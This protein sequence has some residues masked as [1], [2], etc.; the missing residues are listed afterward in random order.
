M[1]KRRLTDLCKRLRTDYGV[2]ITDAAVVAELKALGHDVKSASSSLEE[3]VWLD[4]LRDLAARH[5]PRKTTPER[6]LVKMARPQNAAPPRPNVPAPQAAAPY[7]Q[8]SGEQELFITG[9]SIDATDAHLKAAFA[10]HGKVLSAIVKRDRTTNVSRGFGFVRFAQPVALSTLQNVTVQ[11]V[12][13]RVAHARPQRTRPTLPSAP[14]GAAS[15]ETAALAPPELAWSELRD[16]KGAPHGVLVQASPEHSAHLIARFAELELAGGTPWHGG[17]VGSLVADQLAGA[18]SVIS[19][20]L[21]AGQLMQVIGKP[22]LLAG[23][24]NG[25][26]VM[27]ESADGLL[28]SVVSPGR[29]GIVGNLRFAKTSLAPV[30]APVLAWQVLH[31]I[32]GTVQL[33]QINARLD[34][35]QRGLETLQERAEAEILGQVI[36]AIGILDDILE[37]RAT[38]GTFTAEMSGRLAPVE[39][40]IGSL[41]NRNRTLVERF[42]LKARTAQRHGGKAGAV[43]SA[44]LAREQG[45]QAMHDMELLIALMA[46]DLRVRRA[47]LLVAIERNPK[48]TERRVK[49]VAAKIEEYQELLTNFPSVKQLERHARA[50]VEEMGWWS[51]NVFSRGVVEH[52]DSLGELNLADVRPRKL[53]PAQ[54]TPSYVLWRDKHGVNQVRILGSGTG[55]D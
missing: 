1:S 43:R 44:T 47:L 15:Y 46:G 45:P 49:A 9:V 48:D 35:M 31:A 14:E 52:V 54:P 39:Q 20:G 19:S 37:E 41:F 10:P 4:A 23:L 32:A 55:D 26:L 18:S 53:S 17:A 36:S 16:A 33:Q 7:E 22:H 30:M 13:V 24:R 28:G 29:R 42:R 27:L 3:S 21:Q 11:G 40:T 51:R 2:V 38:T 6:E 5:V 34:A 25:T 8:V 12:K 50:C